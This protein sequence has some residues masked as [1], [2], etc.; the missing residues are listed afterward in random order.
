MRAMN[1]NVASRG[2]QDV[3]HFRPVEHH[4]RQ[5]SRATKSC[6][7]VRVSTAPLAV[8]MPPRR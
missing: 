2:D 7:V 4:H 1:R 3:Q 6:A 5:P 8:R